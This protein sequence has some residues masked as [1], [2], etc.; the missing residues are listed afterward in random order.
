M[1]ERTGDFTCRCGTAM[2]VDLAF[3]AVMARERLP[4]RRWRCPLDDHGVVIGLPPMKVAEPAPPAWCAQH[5]CE[6]PC[7]TCADLM[8]ERRK[9]AWRRLK[10][11]RCVACGAPVPSGSVYYCSE[12]CRRAV[13]QGRTLESPLRAAA[14]KAALQGLGR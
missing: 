12:F 5:E 9:G 1:N 3:N 7:A 10:L 8:R 14:K 11:D 13:N 2:V 6:R 4:Q